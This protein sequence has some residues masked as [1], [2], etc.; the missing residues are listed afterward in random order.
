ML[1]ELTAAGGMAMG[2]RN[3]DGIKLGVWAGGHVEVGPHAGMNTGMIEGSPWGPG[4]LL[5][6]QKGKRFCDE[7]AGGAEGSG[8]LVPRQPK[9]YVVSFADANWKNIVKKIPPCHGAIDYTHG[10]ANKGIDA[11]EAT[12]AALTPGGAQPNDAGV[13]TANTLEELV[14]MVGV[15]NSEQKATAM[16]EL[17]RFNELAAAGKDTDF[18]YDHRLLQGLTTPP[19][20]AVK[21]ETTGFSAGLCQTTGLDTDGD[22]QVLDSNLEP[23]PGLYAA[24]NSSGNRY[25]VQYSSP[26]AGMSLG[27]CLTEGLLLGEMLAKM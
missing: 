10:V 20:H 17:K 15:W 8:Y 5:L 1:D 2:V 26:M 25:I 9:G 6:N 19:F 23:I 7:I 27:Y 4:F 18:G 16:A 3:G 21:Y 22:H 12:M 13:Y 14:E 11:V 24:G